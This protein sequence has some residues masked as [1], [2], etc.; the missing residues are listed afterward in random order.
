MIKTATQHQ[1]NDKKGEL[2][3]LGNYQSTV[4]QIAFRKGWIHHWGKFDGE[5]N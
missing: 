3:L 4:K 5:F 2:N 1:K